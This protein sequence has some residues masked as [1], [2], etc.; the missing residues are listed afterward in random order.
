MASSQPYPTSGAHRPDGSALRLANYWS[1]A[2]LQSSTNSLQSSPHAHT[3]ASEAAPLPSRA[4]R[5]NSCGRRCCCGLR[6]NHAFGRHHRL[7]GQACYVGACRLLVVAAVNTPKQ[8][9]PKPNRRRYGARLRLWLPC[10]R[11]AARYACWGYCRGLRWSRGDSQATCTRASRRSCRRQSR[12]RVAERSHCSHSGTC[13]GRYVSPADSALKARMFH[14][15]CRL[16]CRLRRNPS[17]RRRTPPIRRGQRLPICGRDLS[18]SCRHHEPLGRA[19]A[20]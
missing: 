8:R 3:A 16:C 11:C 2:D 17:H 1:H 14:P 9:A 19:S 6:R 7:V 20:V 5:C 10:L 4:A 13:S 18:G 15:C 12:C